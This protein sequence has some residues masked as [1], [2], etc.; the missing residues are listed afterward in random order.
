MKERFIQP[1]HFEYANASICDNF[2]MYDRN[3]LPHHIFNSHWSQRNTGFETKI[4]AKNHME[5]N[6]P[7]LEHIQ[8][9]NTS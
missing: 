3:L 1:K 4:P 6:I 7:K 5:M 2:G 9:P 8:S